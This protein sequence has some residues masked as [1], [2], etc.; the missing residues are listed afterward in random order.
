M[1]RSRHLLAL[2]ALV[3]SAA[4]AQESAAPDTPLQVAASRFEIVASGDTQPPAK[5]LAVHNGGAALCWGRAPVARFGETVSIPAPVPRGH[6]RRQF[7]MHGSID[8]FV[9]GVNTAGRAYCWGR[10]EYGEL[11]RGTFALASADPVPVLPPAG[12]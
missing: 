4:G 3:T 5:P 2:L 10:G 7:D 9:C 11:G 1:R 12:R 8:P 6:S